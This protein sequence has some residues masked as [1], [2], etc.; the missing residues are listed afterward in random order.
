MAT[1]VGIPEEELLAPG[2]RACAG[3]GCVLAMRYLLKALGRNIIISMATG[4]M[5]V[6]TTPYPE[7][8][9]RVPWIHSAFENAA[10]TAAGIAAGLKALGKKGIK[11]VAIAGDGGTADIGLQALSGAVER[12]DNVLFCCYDNEAYQNTGIQRSGATPFGAWTT[13]TPI[14]KVK[15]GEDRPKKDIPAIIA[16]HG[17]PYVA[18]ASVA[19]P[20]D[21]INKLRKAAAI[22]GPTYVHVHAPCVPGWR[23]E[24]SKT[25]EV[26]RLAVLTGSWVLYEIER[27]QLRVTFKPPKRRP[28]ADYLRLQGRFRHLTDEEIAQIQRMVDEQCRRFGIG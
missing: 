22:E 2:H 1:P 17:A 5:E 6:V 8:S 16:A 9:W 15:R 27:G 28:V 21:F 19:Y 11:S 24:T 12:G 14:G 13:T 26:A 4:C 7:T 18:T 23:I 3:C 25:I 20:L 10:A